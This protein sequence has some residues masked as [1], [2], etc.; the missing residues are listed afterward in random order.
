[1]GIFYDP[2]IARLAALEDQVADLGHML[3]GT[4][5]KDRPAGIAARARAMYAANERAKTAKPA[6]VI[7][8]R[9]ELA[10]RQRGESPKS[11]PRK[12]NPEAQ[13]IRAALK[14]RQAA[15]AQ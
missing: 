9:A 1:M 12:T 4:P 8:V 10:A 11:R 15:A 7:D 14:E 3:A 13:R 2:D 6:A 5:P